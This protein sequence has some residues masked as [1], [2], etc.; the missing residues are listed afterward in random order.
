MRN[1]QGSYPLPQSQT[2]A[3]E[4]PISRED[5]LGYHFRRVELG[6]GYFSAA[7]SLNLSHKLVKMLSVCMDVCLGGTN[8]NRC[9]QRLAILHTL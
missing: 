7:S 4:D 6:C 2:F 8:R 1:F 5:I 9:T 3:C